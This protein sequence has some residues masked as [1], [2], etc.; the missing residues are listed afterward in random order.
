MREV[1][2]VISDERLSMAGSSLVHCISVIEN[3]REILLPAGS[4]GVAFVDEKTC[5]KLHESF[6]DDPEVTDVMTFPGS[7]EDD[8]AG[9]IAI[10]P[11]VAMQ[12]SQHSRMPFN[13]ELSL[14]L[15]HACLHLTGLD[16]REEDEIKEMRSAEEAVMQQLRKAKALLDAEWSG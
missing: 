6:F 15:V 12:A 16:D 9:D 3:C 5:G 13:E 4:L 7:P 11:A 2:L 10:C 8:H 14:Y 1:E